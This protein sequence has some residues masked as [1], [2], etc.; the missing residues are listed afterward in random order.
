MA[1][2]TRSARLK[3]FLAFV[4]DQ[5]LLFW[6]AYR[7][8]IEDK[9]VRPPGIS[10][11]RRSPATTAQQRLNRALDPPGRQRIGQ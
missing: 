7:L 5:L 10:V 6:P 8:E 9:D 2:Q 3:H 4:A 1:P 11:M